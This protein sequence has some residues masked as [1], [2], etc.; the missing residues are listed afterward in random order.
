MMNSKSAYMN[1]FAFSI[2]NFTCVLDAKSIAPNIEKSNF[3]TVLD[4]KKTVDEV[5]LF[6]PIEVAK[7]LAI[8][9]L[10]MVDAREKRIHLKVNLD[11]EKQA[12]WEC[13]VK[14]ADEFKKSRQ[15]V[16][17]NPENSESI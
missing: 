12:L 15:E 10:Q 13:Y 5:Y 11:P 1:N 4:E 16:Q 3:G 14:A 9:I 17:G 8:S 2:Q 7:E 6:M